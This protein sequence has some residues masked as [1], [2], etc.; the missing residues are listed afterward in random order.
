MSV[1]TPSTANKSDVII[2]TDSKKHPISDESNPAYL[3]G[4]LHEAGEFYVRS[5]H[6][7]NLRS[8]TAR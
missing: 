6:F 2:P 5:G 4:A 1:D 3:A 7:M 8:S